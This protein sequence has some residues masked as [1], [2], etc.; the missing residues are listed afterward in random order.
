MPTPLTD[1]KI[2]NIQI[3]FRP[4]A[5]RHRNSYWKLNNS[6]LKHEA[7]T[8]KIYFLI[9]CH[10]Q[11]ALNDKCFKKNWELLKFEIAKFLRQYGS[12]LAK[13]RKEEE[14]K[15]I[16]KITTLTQCAPE[17]LTEDD[18]QELIEQQLKVDEIYRVK[19]EGAY[20]RSRKQWLEEGKQNT[21]YFFR[22]EKS[23]SRTNCIQK[24]NIDGVVTDDPQKIS[25]HCLLFYGNLYTS[26]YDDNATRQFFGHLSQV[27]SINQEQRTHCDK[28]ITLEEVRSAIQQLKLNKSPGTDGLTSEFYITFFDKLAP[29]LHGVFTESIH[30]QTLPPTLYQGLL[31]LIPKSNKDSLRID[32]WR[33]ICLLN[34]D[35]KI[36]A[37]IFAKRLKA[38]LDD[39]TDETQTT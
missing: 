34:N 11:K 4:N 38:V 2:I 1:H 27:K 21:A 24:L 3:N 25:N 28:Q 18:R 15:V 5:S 19:A 20:V 33:P 12:S 26:Q 14:T 32:N 39:I 13:L 16:T 31:T 9:K 6:V 35:Y 7:V 36:L 22:L 8:E 23:R 37:G 10:W 17:D 29:F 30:N